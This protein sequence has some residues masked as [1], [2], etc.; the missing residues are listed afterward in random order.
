MRS[1]EFG[2]ITPLQ[3]AMLMLG[4]R[5]LHSMRPEECSEEEKLAVMGG[6]RQILMHRTGRDF[7]YELDAW[8]GFL[9][10]SG[11]FKREYNHVPA[12]EKVQ[13]VVVSLIDSRER[14]SLMLKLAPQARSFAGAGLS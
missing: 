13:P 9:M 2:D 5:V 4:G 14:R 1:K 8:H 12:W 6:A 11:V 3:A 10:A 7:G